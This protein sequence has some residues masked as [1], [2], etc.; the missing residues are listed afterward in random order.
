MPRLG[1]SIK[2]DVTKIDKNRLFKG[3]KGIYLD[4]T[5]F[6]DTDNMDQFGNHGFISQSTTKEEQQQ[7]IQTPILGNTK[8]FWQDQGQQNQGYQNQAPQNQNQ[9][10]QNQ[11]GPQ[12]QQQDDLPF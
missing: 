3:T 9:A 12:N 4:L 2:I 6:V 11:Q 8:V 5:T 1:L 7:K 10:P